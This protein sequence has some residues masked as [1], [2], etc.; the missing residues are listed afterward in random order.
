MMKIS[1]NN[2]TALDNA[3]KTALRKNVA[4]PG[5]MEISVSNVSV[6]KNKR[7]A[8]KATITMTV[9]GFDPDDVDE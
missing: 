2:G 4:M 9:T 5:G 3:I 1:I 7:G 8:V 6:W